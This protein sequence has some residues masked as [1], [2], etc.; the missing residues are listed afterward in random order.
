MNGI[1]STWYFR[2]AVVAGL[3]FLA[4]RF[5]PVPPVGK[6]AIVAL[7][8]FG[9]A[10]AVAAGVPIVGSVLQGRLPLPQAAPTT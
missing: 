3:G 2:A 7:T 5:L 8:A 1:T 10:G 4:Y 9:V 6:T